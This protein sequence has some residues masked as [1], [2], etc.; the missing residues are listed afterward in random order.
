MP[1]TSGSFRKGHP[2][3]K[4]K[5]AVNQTTRDIKEA[6]RKLIENNLD[7]LTLWLEQIAANDP[8][9]AIKILSDLS[10]YVIPKLARSEFTGK[11]G[12]ALI[13]KITFK[14]FSDD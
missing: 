9:K 4:P 11:D 14:N 3:Y 13:P 12:E 7:N 1:K 10:E 2:G 6:Y 5:G 8:E